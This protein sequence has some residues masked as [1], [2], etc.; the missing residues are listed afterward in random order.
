VVDT[1]AFE[2]ATKRITNMIKAGTDPLEGLLPEGYGS[3]RVIENHAR[4]FAQANDVD[5]AMILPVLLCATSGATQGAFM[6]PLYNEDWT[7]NHV[8]LVFQFFGIAES[9]ARKS[10]VLKEGKQPLENAMIK[11]VIERRAMCAAWQAKAMKAAEAIGVNIDSDKMTWDKVYGG[12]VCASTFADSGTQEGIRNKLIQN[13]GHRVLMT[14]ESDVLREVSAYSRGGAG[15]LG[16]FLRTWDQEAIQVDRA[17]DT[18]HLYMPEASLPFLIFVQPS[19]FSMHTSISQHGY[20]EFT[21]KGVFGRAWLWKMPKP[22]I[23]TTFAFKKKPKTGEVS[24]LMQARLR[25][26]ESL[27]RLVERSNEYRAAKGIRYAWETNGA[28]LAIKED[29][30]PKPERELIDLDGEEG[31]EAFVAVQNMLL[32]LRRSLEEAD[33]L[34]SGVSYQYH[35]LVS[36]FTDHVMRLAALLSLADDP[37]ALTVDT[38]HI[39]DVATRIMPWL[40][41]GWVEVMDFRRSANAE[42]AV[43][44]EMMKNHTFADVST[45]HTVLKALAALSSD[46]GPSAEA[47]FTSGEI[48]ER[49]RRSMPS[50]GRVPGI[51]AHLRKALEGLATEGKLVARIGGGQANAVGKTYD[52]F[53]LTA[54]GYAAVP[55]K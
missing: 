7:P 38:G 14:G 19:S 25:T 50:S 15:S 11:G 31:E 13:G 16:L 47:G 36:R 6:A 37:G 8:A 26:L 49:A 52:R 1:A 10:T 54:A 39:V 45:A 43:S 17:S 32:D 51:S 30:L 44:S 42:A 41:S 20:D 48:A 18:A 12:G 33:A 5:L 24:P 21:D 4:L 29:F 53:K 2:Q 3:D 22:S 23:P 46:D 34:D 27:E 9:G 55:K 35:P 28:S 40:W